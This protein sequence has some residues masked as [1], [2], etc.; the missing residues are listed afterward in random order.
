MYIIKYIF[1][2]DSILFNSS[3]TAL[4]KNKSRQVLKILIAEI[5]RGLMQSMLIL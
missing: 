5:G 1:R 2:K 4:V 3:L